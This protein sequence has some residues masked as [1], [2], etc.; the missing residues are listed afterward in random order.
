MKNESVFYYEAK[1]CFAGKNVLIT[2][3][4]GGIGSLLMASLAYLGAKV[5]VIVKDLK[6]LQ[7]VL[8]DRNI[9]RDLIHVEKMDFKLDQNYREVF[10]NI[11][12]KLGG[13]LDMLFLCHGYFENGEIIETDLKEYDVSVNIN[14][15]S[16]MSLMSLATP[17]LK[18]TQGNIVLISSMESFI[19]VK[20]SFLNT[21]TKSM[22]NSL[23]K[24]AALELAS[25]GVRVNGVAPGVTNTKLRIDKL[26]EPKERNNQIFLQ[27]AGMNNLLSKNV[28]EPGDI[29]DAILFLASD[30]AQFVTGEIIKVD[31]GY[32]LNHDLCF[33]DESNPTPFQ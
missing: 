27:N 2:G 5:A 30:D 9:K 15:R 25:F 12:M 4:T 6:K 18:Y 16:M 8:N 31:N 1:K 29:V 22:V 13:K 20:G 32:S 14:T 11:M 3:A 19:P 33:S 26:E 17:F 24:N 23:I 10:T 28:L 21:V 7:D